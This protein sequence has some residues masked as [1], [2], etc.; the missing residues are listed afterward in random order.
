M[1][2]QL[3]HDTLASDM[4]CII[5][6]HCLV[7]VIKS[8]ADSQHEAQPVWDKYGVMSTDEKLLLLSLCP[9]T[10]ED[11]HLVF[12]WG[13]GNVSISG[14][15]IWRSCVC[16]LRVDYFLNSFLKESLLCFF[17][18][19]FTTS[20]VFF[21]ALAEKWVEQEKIV[22]LNYSNPKRLLRKFYS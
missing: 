1:S 8:N 20:S 6:P 15:P 18:S 17:F 9:W 12:Y 5:P 7:D 10:L 4:Y 19:F 21:R 22:M 16:W 2:E 3:A 13:A 14:V 11:V